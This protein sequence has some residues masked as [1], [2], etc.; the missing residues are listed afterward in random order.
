MKRFVT[1]R[2]GASHWSVTAH[3][4]KGDIT[5]DLNAMNRE[6][7]GRFFSQF[8]RVINQRYGK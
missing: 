4:P 8:R 5:F 6:Q 1:I 2:M 7:K 3:D